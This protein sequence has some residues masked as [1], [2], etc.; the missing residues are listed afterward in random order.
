VG[1]E[2][3]VGGDELYDE[4]DAEQ[5]KSNIDIEKHLRRAELKPKRTPGWPWRGS[6]TGN[7]TITTVGH[8]EHPLLTEAADGRGET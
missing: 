7:G 5:G 3:L 6:C 4:I 8:A 1:Y 2:A